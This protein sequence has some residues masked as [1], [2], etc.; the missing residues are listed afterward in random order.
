[1]AE[2]VISDLEKLN[3]KELKEIA[4]YLNISGYSKI[5]KSNRDILI[6]MIYNKMLESI[7]TGK[8]EE[9]E[10][11]TVS[12]CIKRKKIEIEEEAK[13]KGIKTSK[14]TKKE[15]CNELE[16]VY[17]FDEDIELDN[18]DCDLLYD[19]YTF[20]KLNKMSIKKLY[21]IA[22]ILMLDE[23]KYKKLNKNELIL[24]LASN[25]EGERRQLIFNLE[26]SIKISLNNNEV[27]N[28]K[29]LPY[30]DLVM[31]IDNMCIVIDDKYR[32]EGMEKYLITEINKFISSNKKRISEIEE[33][34]KNA[35]KLHL[36]VINLSDNKIKKSYLDKQKLKELQDLG[37]YL[38]HFGLSKMSK[39][40]L[41]EYLVELF[42]DEE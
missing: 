11:P 12:D 17:N 1:M 27:K 19:K 9:I 41:V 38:G 34:Y 29:E 6:E 25:T 35:S 7:D 31:L 15:L 32:K 42:N 21:N 2:S 14:K 5:T 16:N 37:Y 18:F 26:E 23:Q 8:V 20:S 28:L 13:E 33:Y 3:M 22:N 10:K 4:K 39:K 30:E 24:M 40:E 36:E